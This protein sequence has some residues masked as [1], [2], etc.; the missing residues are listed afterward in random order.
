MELMKQAWENIMVMP[1]PTFISLLKWKSDLEDDRQKRLKEKIEN[2]K[3]K[4]KRNKNTNPKKVL[5]KK[6]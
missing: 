1:Y 4:Q 6:K 3:N 2:I 5:Y